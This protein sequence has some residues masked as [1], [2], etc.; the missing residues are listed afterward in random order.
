MIISKILQRQPVIRPSLISLS[1]L[2]LESDE[3]DLPD[4][5]THSLFNQAEELV[6]YNAFESNVHLKRLA[7]EKFK[8]SEADLETCSKFGEVLGSER[9]IR[10]GYHAN[11]NTP[12]LQTHSRYGKRIDAIDFHPSYHT[13]MEN[14]I[15]NQVH[16]F[17]WENH[18]SSQLAHTTRGILAFMDTQPDAGHG[19]PVTMTF[20][21]I[22]ALKK[23]M[24]DNSDFDGEVWIEKALSNQYDPR[25]LPIHEKNGALIGMS[26]TEKQS[27]SDVRTNTTSATRME[28]NSWRLTGHKWFTSA[29]MCDG[30]LTLAQTD[31]HPMS[32]SCFLV[33]RWIPSTGER[34]KGFQ[35]MRLKS[36]LGDRSNASSEVE[37]RDAY[38]ELVGEEGKGIQTIIEMV[39]CTRLDC[40][41]GSSGTMAH[42][43]A[44]AL[45][46]TSQRSAF[47]TT[48]SHQPLMQNVLMDLIVESQAATLF[49]LRMSHAYSMGE[50]NLFRIATAVGKFF[51]CK[52]QTPFVVE[53][54]ECLGGNGFV[55]DFPLARAFRQSP[56]NS[57]WE[58]SGNVMCL[59]VLR[60][61]KLIP[62]LFEEM[63]KVRGMDSSYDNFVTQLKSTLHSFSTTSTKEEMQIGA[64][65]MVNQ[66]AVGFQASLMLQFGDEPVTKAFMSSRIGTEDLLSTMNRRC[67]GTLESDLIHPQTIFDYT[68][69]SSIK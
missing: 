7:K 56:L 6:N 9:I 11:E 54:L 42:A 60:A 14:S 15:S 22:P 31:D 50:E 66:L 46:H 20:A 3:Y 39:Q 53:C 21:S 32:P 5:D 36:K 26:M 37:Y 17:G 52:Q 45:H 1:T 51:V 24:R 29:P 40:M 62:T 16:S 49:A 23:G 63:D 12:K 47:G 58:G 59:D 8:F 67:Y 13:L 34:N 18:P 38:G 43:L 28:G 33:P 35:V 27:G 55:E 30:F 25:D 65:S 19:C 4:P 68:P 44:Q 48:L 57:I 64:R 61:Q 10:A 69:T 41:L 2:P